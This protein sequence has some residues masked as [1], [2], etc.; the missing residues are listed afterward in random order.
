MPAPDSSSPSSSRFE[1][2][3]KRIETEVKRLLANLNDEVVPA[4]RR[5][6]GKALRAAAEKLAQLAESLDRSR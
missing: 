6:G 4:L 2:A 5:D 3:A 1:E